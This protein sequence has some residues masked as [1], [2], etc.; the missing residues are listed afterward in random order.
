MIGILA[1]VW[2]H[3]AAQYCG[4]I[5]RATRDFCPQP[6]LADLGSSGFGHSWETLLNWD[7]GLPGTTT[8]HRCF[9]S[10]WPSR[11]FVLEPTTSDASNKYIY[12]LRNPLDQMISH[13]HQVWGMGFHYGTE[14]YERLEDGWPVFVRDWLDGYVEMGSWF[15]HVAGWYQKN[16]VLLVRYE[17][18]QAE[19]EKTIRRVAEFVGGSLVLESD[20]ERVLNLT[21]WEAMRATDAADYGLQFLRWMGVLRSH[22]IRQGGSRQRLLQLN[23][24]HVQEMEQKYATILQPLGFPRSWVFPDDE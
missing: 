10:H 19:P 12:V 3:P 11:D 21:S 4:S 8:T 18:L 20:M 13:W 23:E 17:E 5:Q 9:K 1:A 24:S 15:D 2:K 7:G 6:E 14:Q 22:H 16:D